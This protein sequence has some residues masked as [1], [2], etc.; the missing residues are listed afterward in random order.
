MGALEEK[1]NYDHYYYYYYDYDN[2]SRGVS[3]MDASCKSFKEGD[4]ILGRKQFSRAVIDSVQ[5]E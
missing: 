3:T 1:N 5:P 2:Y 4:G